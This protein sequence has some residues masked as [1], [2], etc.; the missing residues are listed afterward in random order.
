MLNEYT[1]KTIDLVAQ[2]SDLTEKLEVSHRLRQQDKDTRDEELTQ[3]RKELQE[4]REKAAES[5][6][7]REDMAVELKALSQAYS[8][9]EEEYRRQSEFTSSAE[10][11]SAT[12]QS[13]GEGSEE[14]NPREGLAGS[15]EVAALRAD[16]A[17]LKQDV[18]A[19][20]DWMAMAY[21]RM[22]TM[23]Q[24]NLSLQ[25]QLEN[26][27]L[28]GMAAQANKDTAG[29]VLAD[30]RNRRQQL[31]KE[32]LERQQR[33]SELSNDRDVERALR[34]ELEVA[35][36]SSAEQLERARELQAELES[37][38]ES[39]K[40]DIEAA[41]STDC[42][43]NGASSEDELKS[44][45]CELDKIKERDQDDIY[46]LEAKVRELE[47]RLSGGL[48]E[49]TVDD[50]RKRD[51]DIQQLQDAN[52]AAQ[53][54]MSRAM[55][56][57]Q[58][59]AKQVAALTEDKAA[60]TERIN[61]LE[62]MLSDTNVADLKIAL[63]NA[64]KLLAD[65]AED[66]KTVIAGWQQAYNLAEANRNE[67]E[68]QLSAIRSVPD[69]TAVVLELEQTI[70]TLK[71]QL[72][73]K[74]VQFVSSESPAEFELQSTINSLRRQLEEQEQEARAA[75][76]GWQ[77]SYIEIESRL[78][79]VRS[80]H[81]DSQVDEQMARV[82]K[83]TT[84]VEALHRQLQE[85]ETD[86][87][88]NAA[89]VSELQ[90]ALSTLQR[91]CDSV[92][93]ERERHQMVETQ[94]QEMSLKISELES[95]VSSL[96]EQLRSRDTEAQQAAEKTSNLERVAASLREEL[97]AQERE[98]TEAITG[99]QQ[100]YDQVSQECRRLQEGLVSAAE[101]ESIVRNLKEQ[102]DISVNRVTEL[103]ATNANL[104]QKLENQDCEANEALI[105]LQRS[106]DEVLA[107]SKE[108]EEDL[109][110]VGESD[111]A[112]RAELV[113]SVLNLKEQLESR[114]SE[115]NRLSELQNVVTKLQQELST[116]ERKASETIT[117]W[118]SSYDEVL[119]NYRE[120]EK[121]V[122][123]Q[124]AI[125]STGE[126]DQ[127][128]RAKLESLVSDLRE[129]LESRNIDG[130]RV[131][132][133]EA[134]ISNLQESIRTQEHEAN[135]VITGWQRS[136][137][138]I[139]ERCK[140][141]EEELG[142]VGRSHD[143]S[144]EELENA[145]SNLKEQLEGQTIDGSRVNELESIVAHLQKELETREREAN[146][147][148]SG[149]Q[150]SYND[151][152]ERCQG[153]EGTRAGE[154]N[155]MEITVSDLKRQLDEKER[156]A[157]EKITD[158]QN[159]YNEL[160]ERSRDQA[161]KLTSQQQA[162]EVELSSRH[163]TEADIVDLRQQLEDQLR[164]T[165]EATSKVTELEVVAA[166][167]RRDLDS[168]AREAHDA[169]LV[170]QHKCSEGETFKL[171]L[172]QQVATLKAEVESLGERLQQQEQ[173][174]TSAIEQW[175]ESY[176]RLE[177]ELNKQKLPM[178]AQEEL[179]NLQDELEK[180]KLD[181]SLLRESNSVLLAEKSQL[182]ICGES[183]SEQMSSLRSEVGV[184]RL[185]LAQQ[186]EEA[187]SAISQWEESYQTLES[188]FSELKQVQEELMALQEKLKSVERDGAIL[189]EENVSLR[190]ANSQLE[191]QLESWNKEKDK[192]RDFGLSDAMLTLQAEVETLKVCLQ[193]QEEGAANTIT[194]L[195]ENCELLESKLSAIKV[196]SLPSDVVSELAE[197][198]DE[199]KSVESD[200]D[201]LRNNNASLLA[202]KSQLESQVESLKDQLLTSQIAAK[203]R[204]SVEDQLRER[205]DMQD[206][207][208]SKLT[209]RCSVLQSEKDEL[210]AK[211]QATKDEKANVVGSLEE[212]I[213][214]L[215]FELAEHDE[216][217]NEAI[218]QWQES[219]SDAE[220]R[221]ESLQS[222]KYDIEGRI[223]DLENTV[224]NLSK[225][226]SEH[227]ELAN[228]AI[229]QWQESLS[230]AE[231]RI[232]ALESEKSELERRIESMEASLAASATELQNRRASN[233]AT[234][235][236]RSRCRQLEDEL[237]F[238][239]DQAE[240]Y[241]ATIAERDTELV[242]LQRRVEVSDD[243]VAAVRE[244][245]DRLLTE[246]QEIETR[247]TATKAE[248]E[249]LAVR[250]KE[251][252]REHES[253]VRELKGT[254]SL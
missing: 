246:V 217:A 99:W 45:Q 52:A 162:F 169:I 13:Q 218:N 111:K 164:Q 12:L 62:S 171:E 167:L 21:E 127:A 29:R 253:A 41:R 182:Q 203:D 166:D 150:Q 244:E 125:A 60:L 102:L 152:L 64:E 82:E 92:D 251:A 74:S 204:D 168:Q 252:E 130:N 134:V 27:H 50:I 101:L 236:L 240:T 87:A 174:A 238:L 179:L 17:R 93:V 116:Q 139:L 95:T 153:L 14:H 136:Y 126:S 193:E 157:N 226:L 22:N 227:D 141:L 181:A 44:L 24:E 51:D 172:D 165:S 184:L 63:I 133:L 20:E 243:Q 76:E 156:E 121:K 79:D 149:W 103:E 8:N 59:L 4:A 3:V 237:A 84:E 187:T 178:D 147:A 114:N 75:I 110:L 53:A 199:L 215:R 36:N 216:Q 192:A 119:G 200:T 220:A 231:V 173:E 98:A 30:E 66:A 151:V 132:E 86:A 85:K 38:V 142:R 148:I 89:K 78:K 170:W 250:L 11:A 65:Q 233:D 32:L 241:E 80:V 254:K 108:L 112:S 239:E 232:Q 18:K 90:E 43:P 180:L 83:L 105:R 26:V 69:T 96:Q 49:Y 188:D 158:W 46:K 145:V 228:E 234:D 19:A 186:Q 113:K 146:E 77:Q 189:R 205:V 15:T 34:M 104:Q 177:S 67:L 249:V 106:Y 128:T 159:R 6:R 163:Q 16:N 185:R 176:R 198:K 175:E 229:N 195:E 97:E 120:L 196:Q 10:D 138:E 222:E 247:L 88:A 58:G 137:D 143:A 33:E 73:N 131:T 117:G 28:I 206:S 48:G 211:L 209:I 31:E 154:T 123:L 40:R 71:L 129:Q 221:F 223:R 155:N 115:G 208:I 37:T 197:L 23:Q 235:T 55:E 2:V 190:E 42:L 70:E 56:Q 230:E 202:T 9:L 94:S 191:I 118:K 219:L 35:L 183:L 160:V 242:E 214:S 194:R 245:N 81:Q 213:S 1:A 135:E 5:Q 210:E 224:A 207:E 39:L 91:K 122:A 54:W 47:A 109:A 107:R 25:T 144:R 100:S 201:L 140:G 68:T 212:T 248:A 124:E 57:N 225:E 61:E 72:Q 161:D 7:E